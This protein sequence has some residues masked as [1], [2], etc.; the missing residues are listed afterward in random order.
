[1][2][3]DLKYIHQ[4]DAEDALGVAEKQPEQLTASFSLNPIEGP[5]DNIVF[6]GMGGSALAALFSK[7]WP[8]HK[9]PFEVCRQYHIPSYVSAKTL[10]IASSYSGNTEETLSGLAEAEQKN[11]K[12][13]VIASGGKL[14]E[15]A[16]Q[17]N[18]PHIVLP[19]AG[20]PRYAVFYSFRALVTVLVAAGLAGDSQ[21]DELKKV[22]DFLEQAKQNWLPTVPTDKNSAKKL[23]YELAGKAAVVYAGPLMSPAAYKW[24]ISFNENA[25]NLAWWNEYPEWNHNETSGWLA[26][27]QDK[28]YSVVELRSNLEHEH[29]QKRFEIMAKLLSGKRPAPEVV[30]AE[31]DDVLSQM[32]WTVMFGDFV[33]LYLAL[34][35]NIDPSPVTVQ[36]QIKKDLG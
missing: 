15:I 3:D 24:K 26:Q 13:V 27:P 5:I 20:Q 7:T 21:L 17:K 30:Q 18:Y 10:F 12:I 31:G 32:L 14:I 35:N 1:M 8:G 19:T 25:K 33:T 11:A 29:V 16:K 36:E 2:L 23:A 28:L 9:V 4:R 34:L 6:A 22:A